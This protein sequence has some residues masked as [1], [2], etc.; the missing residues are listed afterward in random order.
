MHV[1]PKKTGLTIVPN[2]LMPMR[3]Q[4]G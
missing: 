2:E 4:N 3:V 1:V